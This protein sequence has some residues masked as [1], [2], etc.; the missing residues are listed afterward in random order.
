MA[1]ADLAF[2]KAYESVFNEDGTIKV[3]GREACK[4]LIS[5]CQAKDQNTY[6]GNVETGQICLSSLET[7]KKLYSDEK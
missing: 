5:A 3:C 4:K 6:F 7:I 2:R 1:K